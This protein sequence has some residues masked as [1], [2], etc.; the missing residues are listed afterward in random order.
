MPRLRTN[1]DVCAATVRVIDQEKA[2]RFFG[3]GVKSEA[4]I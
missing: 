2:T 4:F 1:Y 3:G